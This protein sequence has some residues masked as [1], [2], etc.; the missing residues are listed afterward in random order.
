MN[1]GFRL[2]NGLIYITL[3]LA[4][5]TVLAERITLSSLVAGLIISVIVYRYWQSAL[6]QTHPIRGVKQIPLWVLFV[7]QLVGAIIVANFQVAA[8]VLSKNLPIQPEIV[9]YRTH[10]KTDFLKTVLANSITLTPGTMSVD[11]QS[12]V[13]TIHCLNKAYADSLNGNAFEKT[14]L[15][16]Q[17][18]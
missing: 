10:L 7:L 2:K 18:V 11:I 15:R 3:F 9:E 8:I 16:I 12:D 13:L 5:W 14:L 6:E 17:E 1:G 4:F